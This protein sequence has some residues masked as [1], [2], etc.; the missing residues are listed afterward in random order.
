MC[1]KK[2][3]IP[4]RMH[5]SKMTRAKKAAIESTKGQEDSIENVHNKSEVVKDSKSEEV[6]AS[7]VLCNVYNCAC[8][9]MYMG[10][11]IVYV[12]V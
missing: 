3:S 2:V 7:K 9:C 12:R 10:I 8:V 5:R 6:K 1:L 4:A 11:C